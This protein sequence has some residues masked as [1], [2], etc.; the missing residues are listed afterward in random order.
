MDVINL[1]L[2]EPEIEP[3]RDVVVAAIERRG[4]GGRR[5]DDRGGERVR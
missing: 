3:A 5:A 1:S 2:G 4:E